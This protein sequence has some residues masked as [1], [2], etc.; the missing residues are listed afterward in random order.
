MPRDKL[1][2]PTRMK[3]YSDSTE[4]E[5]LILNRKMKTNIKLKMSLSTF[6]HAENVHMKLK[7]KSE[8]SKF[9]QTSLTFIPY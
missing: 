3:T 1:G 6:R 4:V 2:T 8:T 7:Y 9:F 5:H